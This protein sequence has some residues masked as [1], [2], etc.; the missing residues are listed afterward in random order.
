MATKLTKKLTKKEKLAKAEAIK[1]RHQKAASKLALSSA[2]DAEEARELHEQTARDAE[3]LEA[4][5]IIQ[6]PW[7]KVALDWITG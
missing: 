7:W 5:L 4:S 2:Q 6:R 1:V 3:E